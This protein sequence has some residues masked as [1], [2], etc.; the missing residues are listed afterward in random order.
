MKTRVLHFRPDGGGAGGSSDAGAAAGASDGSAAGGAP[1]AGSAPADAGAGAPA[2]GAGAPAGAVAGS[3]GAPA[4]GADAAK[5][6]ADAAA[7]AAAAA[8][9][10]AVPEKYELKLPEAS[11]LDASAIERTTAIARELGLPNDAAAQ[12]VLDFVNQEAA[13]HAAAQREAFLAAHQP[14]GAEW[15][16][17]DAAYREAALADAEIGGTPEKL[18]ASSELA[19]RAFAQFADPEAAEFFEKSGLGSHPQVLRMLT[20]IG[21]AMGEGTLVRGG[22]S[23]T[24]ATRPEDRLYPTMKKE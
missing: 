20:R 2:G 18:A 6:A 10:P 15:V 9:P 7:A 14:G 22:S 3:E 8:K 12:K 16:K 24:A 21:K 19:K 23:T 4:A 13:T 17:Q 1:A 11:T 5:A